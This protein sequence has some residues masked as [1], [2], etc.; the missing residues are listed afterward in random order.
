MQAGVVSIDRIAV[1]EKHVNRFVG[2]AGGIVAIGVAAGDGIDT[3]PEKLRHAAVRAS[4]RPAIARRKAP[5]RLL[6]P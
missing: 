3:L 5:R 4:P 1:H 6:G 2:R